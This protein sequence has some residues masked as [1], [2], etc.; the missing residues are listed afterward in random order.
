MESL[1][2]SIFGNLINI[3]SEDSTEDTY[4]QNIFNYL[5]NLKYQK[6]FNKL[7]EISANLDALKS[8]K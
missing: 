1:K 2:I 7:K 8:K 6:D 3:H 4:K 5:E